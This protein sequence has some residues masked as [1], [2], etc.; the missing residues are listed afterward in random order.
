RYERA[1][2]TGNVIQIT[3]DSA[4]LTAAR[5]SMK[6]QISVIDEWQLHDNSPASRE[7]RA[8][9]ISDSISL[10][11]APRSANDK[12][13]ASTSAKICTASGWSLTCIIRCGP[14]GRTRRSQTS[15]VRPP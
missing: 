4:T 1:R 7:H 5:K 12:W 13:C 15:V 11:M 8:P 14:D 10:R 9:A 2:A 6:W 3:D